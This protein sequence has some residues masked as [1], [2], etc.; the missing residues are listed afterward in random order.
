MIGIGLGRP[1]G[2]RIRLSV[3][4]TV[5]RGSGTECRTSKVD[6]APVAPPIRGKA[7]IKREFNGELKSVMTYSNAEGNGAVALGSSG[8]AF[9]LPSGMSVLSRSTA[10]ISK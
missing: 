3:L 5:W 7:S 4:E 1:G 2:D 10:A 8:S 6:G 9:N